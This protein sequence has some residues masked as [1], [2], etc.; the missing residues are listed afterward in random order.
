LD[1]LKKGDLS[2]AVDMANI[3]MVDPTQ[4]EVMLEDF[5]EIVESDP[6]CKKYMATARLFFNDKAKNAINEASMA[7]K[8]RIV[9]TGEK[10]IPYEVDKT[11]VV[12]EVNA[13]HDVAKTIN[14]YGILQAVKNKAPQAL[15]MTGLNNIIE[16][17]IDQVATVYG[18]S[19][20]VKNFNKVWNTNTTYDGDLRKVRSIMEENWGKRSIKHIEQAVQ[21]LQGARPKNDGAL[22][23]AYRW[24]RGNTIGATFLLNMSV[25]TKQIGS[26]FTAQSMIGLK[27][28]IT[29]FFNLTKTMA[30]FKE[31][32][33]EIDKYTATA[34]MRRQGV[35]DA[36]MTTLMTEG[37]RNW[38]GRYA[39]K[40]PAW[41]NPTKWIQAMDAAVAMSLWKYCKQETAK[42]TKLKGEALLIASAEFFDD[43]V[44]HTQSMGDVL[45]RPEMQKSGDPWTDLLGLFKT[46]LYQ[47]AG[48]L[49]TLY[50][51]MQAN[52]NKENKRAVAR[53]IV[54]IA[55][56][57]LWGQVMTAFFAAF[58]YKMG[59]YKDEEDEVTV[60][61]V[62]KRFAF[63]MFAD[64][65]G[66]VLPLFGSE[67]AGI[68]EAIHYKDTSE[69]FSNVA[70][71]SVNALYQGFISAITKEDA[72][73][74]DWMPVIIECLSL[75]GV[76]ANNIYR[77]INAIIKHIKDIQEG[78]FLSFSQK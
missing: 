10:Y 70:T 67:M 51:E 65:T 40:A 77:F 62:A 76:P 9:A 25:V 28:P 27:N 29:M 2:G 42:R 18:L 45:H 32:S 19:V 49:R 14:G 73:L 30:N 38:L 52:P 71:D 11:D 15:I 53:T 13:A 37:Q 3:H 16:R 43:V 58:R 50:G 64:L 35:S 69:L 34:W 8:H 36:E 59:R 68:I 72:D 46:D 61:S 39:A 22:S 56:S 4:A 63:G 75:L 5:A 20:P 31:I 55:M 1:L 66:Y 78:K 60:A 17:H 7:T 48:Q 57:S 24:V 74:E 33:A 26:L 6:W 47:S 41:R 54:G 44:E 23:G 12:K 21:D